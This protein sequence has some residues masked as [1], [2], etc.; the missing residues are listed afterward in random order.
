LLTFPL[1]RVMPSTTMQKW[2]ELKDQKVS[3]VSA[4]P[5]HMII[6]TSDGKV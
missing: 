6:V 3:S 2:T 1:R 5:K 4:G